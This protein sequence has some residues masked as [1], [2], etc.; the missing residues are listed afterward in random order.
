MN[1]TSTTNPIK[2]PTQIILSEATWDELD[3]ADVWCQYEIK[4]Q[5]DLGN[6]EAINYI[7]IIRR[8]IINTKDYRFS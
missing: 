6:E 7:R 2:P 1:Q 3:R 4:R 5:S 8:M